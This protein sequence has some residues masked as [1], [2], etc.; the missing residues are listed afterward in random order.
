MVLKIKIYPFS[1][2]IFEPLSEGL[3][4]HAYD[5]KLKKEI[6]LCKFLIAFL[7]NGT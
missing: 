4:L 5:V 2:V 7:F 6:I 1:T 3:R